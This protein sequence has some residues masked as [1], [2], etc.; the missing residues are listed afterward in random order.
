MTNFSTC[1][2]AQYDLH[3]LAGIFTS[4]FEGYF[5]PG[6]TSAVELATRIRLEQ[7]DLAL[8]RVLLAGQEP[9]GMALLARRGERVWCGGFGVYT[10]WRGRGLANMLAVDMLGAAR[11]AG[12]RLFELEVLT[13]NEPAI[14]AYQRAGLRSRREL[15]VYSWKRNDDAPAGHAPQAEEAAPAEL[16]E[17]FGALHPAAPAWQRDLPTLLVREEMRGLAL[18]SQNG[19]RGYLLYTGDERV[20]LHDLAASDGGAARELLAALQACCSSIVSVNEPSDSPL[21]PAFPETGFAEADRQLDLWCQ[22]H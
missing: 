3:T 15:L 12:A 18:R 21:T 10:P 22:L 16:L 1:S 19:L 7:I 2:A 14:R 11:A 6:G 17:H 9:A 8:S 20:R 13:R 5:Y 4:A